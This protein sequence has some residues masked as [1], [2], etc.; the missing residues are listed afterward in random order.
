MEVRYQLRYS[1]A[2]LARMSLA[3]RGQA[4]EDRTSTVK[5]SYP[6]ASATLT[7]SPST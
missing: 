6:A 4:L 1:P 5:R 7:L 2:T 3:L